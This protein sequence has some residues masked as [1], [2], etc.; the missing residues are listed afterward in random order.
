MR[1][2]QV[3][4][5]ANSF[6]KFHKQIVNRNDQW[7]EQNCFQ[8]CPKLFLLDSIDQVFLTIR[9]KSNSQVAGNFSHQQ[10][11]GTSFSHR[12]IETPVKKL[13]N[14]PGCCKAALMYLS[15]EPLV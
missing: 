7:C 11:D 6:H 1:Y 8:Y 5:V 3:S 4:V 13:S 15:T 14:Q 12:A 2:G 9:H 10:G